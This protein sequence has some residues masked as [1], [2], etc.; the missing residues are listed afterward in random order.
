MIHSFFSLIVYLHIPHIYADNPN[1]MFLSIV[2]VP[3]YNYLDKLY[4]A[5]T[6]YGRVFS[7]DLVMGGGHGGGEVGH[8]SASNIECLKYPIEA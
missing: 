4:L 8:F 7:S 6:F 3:G 5:F 2:K 1:C